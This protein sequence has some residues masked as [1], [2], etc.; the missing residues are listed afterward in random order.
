MGNQPSKKISRTKSKEPQPLRQEHDKDEAKV[1]GPVSVG[2]TPASELKGK[3]RTASSASSTGSYDPAT[4]PSPPG[5]IPLPTAPEES[6]PVS[7]PGVPIPMGVN[8]VSVSSLV[9]LS[10]VIELSALRSRRYGP[11]HW[12]SWPLLPESEP[13]RKMDSCCARREE[14]SRGREGGVGKVETASARTR[15]SSFSFFFTALLLSQR[16]EHRTRGPLRQSGAW[17]QVRWPGLAWLSPS[18]SA[19]GGERQLSSLGRA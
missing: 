19:V 13:W 17:L 3:Q 2:R 11:W 16:L 4:A 9:M 14:R 15:A 6:R 10:R 7:Q 12:A 8:E 18:V 5:G 1:A